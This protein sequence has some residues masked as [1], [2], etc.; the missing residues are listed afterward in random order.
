MR[1]P[2]VAVSLMLALLA[3]P[4]CVH[5]QPAGTVR[6]L[7][8]LSSGPAI[9]PPVEAFR[10]ALRELGWI[11]GQNIAIEYR[12]TDGQVEQLPDLC[13]TGRTRPRSGGA[14]RPSWIG[15]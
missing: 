1:N 3:T 8:F 6:R 5:A 4:L 11:E 2:A 10:Q 13:P 15:S 7:G 9:A 14:Q 12:F